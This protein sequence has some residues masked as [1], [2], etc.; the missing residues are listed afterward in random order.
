MAAVLGAAARRRVGE[1]VFAASHGNPFFAR[2]A[3]QALPRRRRRRGRGRPGPA[4]GRR[5][6]R[7][8]CARAPRC[9]A[10]CSPG[11]PPTSSWPRSWPCSAGSRCAISPLVERLTR[12]AP[13]KW[14]VRSTGW[15]G[16]GCCAAT[17]AATRSPTRSCATR[18]TR[19]S[20]RPSGAASTPPSRPRWPP[21]GG[22]GIVLDVAGAGH[23]RRRVGRA[24]RRGG[25]RGAAGGRAGRGR[26]RPAGVGRATSGRAVEVLPRRRRPAGRRAGHAG[27]GASSRVPTGGGRRCRAG[28]PRRCST[29]ARRA[30]PPRPS[31]P[32]TCT[33]AGRIDA[34][35]DV[36]EDRAGARRRALPAG[37][38]QGVPAVPGGPSRRRGRRPARRP[39][40]ARRQPGR[41]HPDPGAPHPVREPRPARSSSPT[42]CS[43][44]MAAIPQGA[45][46]T[47]R[48]AVH[49]LVAFADWRPGPVA[50]IAAPRRRPAS[51]GPT[52]RRPA[53]AACSRPARSGPLV[54]GDWDEALDLTPGRRLRPRAAG[55][56][57]RQPAAALRRLRDPRRPGALDQ[58]AADGR[59]RSWT[60]WS[61]SGATRPSCGPAWPARTRQ[62]SA[63]RR[64]SSPVERERQPPEG[65]R[66][67][68]AEVLAELVE[69]LVAPAAAA[70]RAATVLPPSWSG[71]RPPPAGPSA[72]P[73]RLRARAWSTGDVE[74]ARAYLERADGRALGGRAGPRTARAR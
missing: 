49:E 32:T 67:K 54:A 44:Q 66:W 20:D 22:P 21:S 69:V 4:G 6:R 10:G 43:A 58:A 41:P 36:V 13:T 71:W 46:Q 29:P 5:A 30:A 11:P 42:T 17:G 68:L 33:S 27:P 62:R 18:S 25:G 51:S 52:P 63:R 24:G 47:V 31:S 40:R 45:S 50:R 73:P 35:I 38:D 74:V 59:C 70:R 37:G 48:L 15:C 65:A 14:L 55:R 61:R 2:E 53:S 57:D 26:H 72:R 12:Q 39:R 7:S 23:P 16:R 9:C 8:G 34:A 3:A 1:A 64:C 56:A 28:R 60:R 19:T